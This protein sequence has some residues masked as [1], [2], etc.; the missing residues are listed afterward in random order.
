MEPVTLTTQRLLL[1]PH[2]PSDEDAVFAACQDPDIQRWTD[3]PQPYERKHAASYLRDVV[4]RGWHDETM[5]HFAA[6]HRESGVLVASVNV[7]RHSD[8]WGIGYWTV[9]EHRG[10]GYATES[11]RALADWSFT[12]R[13][14]QRLE[15]RAEAG[16]MGSWAVAEKVGFLREGTLRA[17]QTNRNGLRDTWVGALLPAD[18]G[19]P[20]ALPYCP[21][22]SDLPW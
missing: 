3:L 14:V 10:R 20:F 22:K 17:A 13:G 12:A 9:A 5:Y 8:T 1:R 11:V 7:H 16:N 2:D 6:L 19:L 18:L 21:T 4:P 15:W